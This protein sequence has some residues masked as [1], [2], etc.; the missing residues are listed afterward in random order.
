MSGPDGR[1]DELD[2]IIELAGPHNRVDITYAKK[3]L[4]KHAINKQ[5]LWTLNLSQK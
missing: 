5:N 4:L 2:N 1:Q 3:K